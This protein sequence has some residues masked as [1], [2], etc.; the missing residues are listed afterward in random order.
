MIV[1]TSIPPLHRRL[2]AA[3]IAALV[4]AGCGGSTGAPSGGSPAGAGT[5]ASGSPGG[6]AVLPV[7]TNPIMNT[8]TAANL[9]IDKLRVENN[10]DPVTNK[11]TADHIE[12]ALRNKSAA[13]LNGFEVYYTF[14]DASAG[15]SESYYAKLPA[16]FSIPA[17]GGRTIS[18]DN[19]GK[20]D[21]FPVN[22][23]NLY[24]TSKNA[25]QVKVVVSAAGAA[26]Q[27]ATVTKAAGGAET[28]D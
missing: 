19:T 1:L 21:H 11:V 9:T 6:K 3:G 23:F 25:L 7:T 27:T 17:G 15:S 8:S 16:S 14:T 20:P 22:K 2:A 13:P 24:H 26:V 12:I 5:S 4:V 18:F 28:A 10:V